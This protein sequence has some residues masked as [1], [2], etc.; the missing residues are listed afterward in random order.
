MALTL[1]ALL[2]RARVIVYTY[3]N[4][5]SGRLLKGKIFEKYDKST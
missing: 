4:T 1:Y 5:E 3:M 2:A